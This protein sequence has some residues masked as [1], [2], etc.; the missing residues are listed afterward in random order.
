MFSARRETIQ[1]RLKEYTGLRVASSA[2]RVVDGVRGVYVLSGIAAK[3]KPVNILYSNANF[4]ICET[5]TTKSS[6]LKLYDE[7]IVEGKDLYDGKM[8]K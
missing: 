5:D 7:V 8:V 4:T 6:S 1:I 3:F 2:V